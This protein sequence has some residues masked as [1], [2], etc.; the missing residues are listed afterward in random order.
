MSYIRFSYADTK[1]FTNL[2]FSIN[3]NSFIGIR[4]DSGL[5]KTTL[6]DILLGFLTPHAG[7]MFVNEKKKT[8]NDLKKL[9]PQIS[10]VKQTSFLL[11]DSI[12]NNIILFDKDFDKQKLETILQVTGLK[13]WIDKLAEGINTEITESGKNIS[14]GQKQR[15]AIARALYKDAPIIILDE[16]FNELDEDSE[17][18][19]LK[20]FKSLSK[21]WENNFTDNT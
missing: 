4:G 10:Y 9:W 3:K 14:G 20:Y 13:E 1:V 11:H 19:L 5:G 12:L 15:I 21:K 16:P 6:I 2:S 7:N 18:N 8:P 17:I